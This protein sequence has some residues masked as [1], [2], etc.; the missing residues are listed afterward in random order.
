SHDRVRRLAVGG[1]EARLV[2]LARRRGAR[3][4]IGQGLLGGITVLFYLPPAVSTAQ[5][6]PG[7]N[8]LRHHGGDCALHIA[9]VERGCAFGRRPATAPTWPPPPPPSSTH[10]FSSALR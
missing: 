2:A 10:R 6:G 5:R 7:R 3:R 1:R 4:R 8:L 9:P